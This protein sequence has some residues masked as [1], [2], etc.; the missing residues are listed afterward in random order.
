MYYYTQYILLTGDNME[1][2]E[3]LK[4]IRKTLN[5]TQKIYKRNQFKLL[6]L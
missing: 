4:Y 1:I 3:R 5:L 6:L 2:F